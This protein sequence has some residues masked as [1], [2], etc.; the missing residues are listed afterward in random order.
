MPNLAAQFALDAAAMIND[1]PAT[2]K[3]GAATFGVSLTDIGKN[4]RLT[5]HGLVEEVNA[6]ATGLIS[7]FP[8]APKEGQRI[9]I[10]P[11]GTSTAFVNYRIAQVDTAADGA[12]YVLLLA[13]D[14]RELN[15]K[16]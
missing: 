11:P 8:S 3:F 13:S 6:R 15:A 7:D 12:C 4:D 1:L 5:A 14:K 2:A 16:P 9:Q 10:V